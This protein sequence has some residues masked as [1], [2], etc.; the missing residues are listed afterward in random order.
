[1]KLRLAAHKIPIFATALVCVLLY[2]GASLAFP[3]F[4]SASVFV[5]FFNDNAVLG[6]AALGL[7][8]VI[9]SGGIDLSVGSVAGFTSILVAVLLEKHHASPWVAIPAALLLGLSFGLSLG[10]LIHFFALPPFLATLAG[11][12]L[13]R[14]LGFVIQMESIAINHPLY[15]KVAD[16]RITLGKLEIP[17]AA[18][19]FVLLCLLAAGVAQFTRFGRNVYA[20]GGSES[21]A[22]LMGL[23][24]ARTKVGVYGLSGFCA[25]LAG[26]VYTF[27]TSSGNPTTGTGLELD[28]IAAVVIGGTLLTG[29]VGYIG[30]TVLGVMILGIIQTGIT[31]KG[32]LSS[33]WTK[34]AIG[35]LLLGFILLQKLL[36]SKK[37]KMLLTEK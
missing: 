19:F 17:A 36:Q 5:N 24:V 31:F 2:L 10:A 26:V 32:T 23:P 29:G 8:F 13:V 22:L 27:Y 9:L 34:I 15:T 7:S 25:A 21:S 20:L 14:G 37:V 12:F 28:A 6:I 1:M 4:F 33:W 3:G 35:L 11:M 30:G 16:W 18:L